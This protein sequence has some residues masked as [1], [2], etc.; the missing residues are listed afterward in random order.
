ML[1]MPEPA[2]MDFQL[3]WGIAG[4]GMIAHDFITAL[5]T[6]P[7]HQHKVIAI[8]GKDLERADRLASLHKIS[9]VYEGYESLA[10][11]DSIDIVFVSVLNLQHY[12]ITRLMLENNKHVLCEKPMGM[13]YK[14]TKS[15]VDLAREK[16]LFLLEGMWSRFFPA[17]DALDRHI[18][19]GGL[20]DIY[21]ISVQFGVEINDIERNLMKDLGGGVILDLGIYMLQLVQFI[22]K[23]PPVDIVCTGHL[24]KAGVD[25][26]VSCALKY[27][28]GR[29]ATLA[30][31][32][33]AT[34]T[35]KAD[36]IG[37]KGNLVLDYFWCPTVLHISAANSTEWSLPKGKYKF[38]FH[39]S[40]GLSYQI[41]E[42]WDC[43]SKGETESPKMS[44]DES[45]LLSKLTDTMRTQLGILENGL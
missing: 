30:A 25:E 8:A 20:G 35:N 9:T 7:A 29:T 2:H 15:L 31:H 22:Y 18:S 6:L 44:L 19:S 43:I 3:R 23:E 10:R 28:D 16:K 26:S 37:T 4:V 27:K 40:A 32:T 14:Q 39:N 12:E 38:H 42:C 13:T 1:E 33:R 24:S 21:H 11:D 45:I 5:G 17:Y 36:I 34:M 41:Q